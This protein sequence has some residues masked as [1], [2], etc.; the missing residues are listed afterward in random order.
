MYSIK[1]L[2]LLVLSSLFSLNHAFP[3]NIGRGWRRL[4]LYMK[5][6]EIGLLMKSRG[7]FG[8]VVEFFVFVI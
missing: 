3:D 8:M 2:K 1:S 6:M 7:T 5:T 4:R